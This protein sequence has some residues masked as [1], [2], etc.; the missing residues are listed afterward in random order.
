MHCRVHHP[1]V[2]GHASLQHAADTAEQMGN[3]GNMEVM[4]HHRLGTSCRI[5]AELCI[6]AGIRF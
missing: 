1:N 5:D 3:K 2:A 4:L 6:V